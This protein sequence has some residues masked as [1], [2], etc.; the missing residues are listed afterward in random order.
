MAA[1]SR[2]QGL[3]VTAAGYGGMSEAEIERKEAHPPG[4][5][6]IVLVVH[7]CWVAGRDR[8]LPHTL[9]LGAPQVAVPNVVGQAQGHGHDHPAGNGGLAVGPVTSTQVNQPGTGSSSPPTPSAGRK[10]GQEQPGR[11]GGQRRAAGH[12]SPNVVGKQLAQ[13]NQELQTASELRIAP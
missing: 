7:C 11:P 9:H 1:A 12:Q 4:N 5:L 2:T 10:R 13:A 6:V 8:L 3:P